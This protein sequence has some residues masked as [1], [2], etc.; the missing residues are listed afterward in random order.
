MDEVKVK[1][2][3]GSTTF[4]G[5]SRIGLVEH[6]AVPCEDGRLF[7]KSATNSGLMS[8]RMVGEV[9]PK[10]FPLLDGSH[11][12]E[13]I[14]GCMSG[15]LKPEQLAQVLDFLFQKG[16]VK[17]IEEPP[18]NLSNGELKRYGSVMRYFS[19]YG[20]RYA[21]LSCFRTAN[22]GIVNA[23]PIAPALASSLV[24][25]GV[26]RLTLLGGSTVGS[27]EVQQSR[28]YQPQDENR[29]R[30]SVWRERVTSERPDLDM[31]LISTDIEEVVDWQELIH[32]TS[33]LIVFLQGPLLFNPWLDR[34]NEAAFALRVPWLTIALLDGESAQIGPTIR[35]GVTACYKCF[36]TRLKSNFSFIGRDEAV[37]KYLGQ[38]R[39]RI[40][41]GMLPPVADIVGGFAAIEVM[42]TLSPETVAQTSG[43][44]MLFNVADFTT[45]FHPV[46]KLPRCPVCS[47]VRNKP[48]PRVW[49]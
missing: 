48:K 44:F 41:F 38:T 9:F 40:D 25:F 29:D 36:E 12:F 34:L 20:S 16:F 13:D 24:H 45:E 43:R 4:N 28:Y 26:A 42:R 11:G 6:Y 15:V 7:M 46:L 3:G 23:G 31:K 30:I 8:G 14:A 33:M 19:R 17:E 35:P 49:S 2:S 18:P 39:E 27:M 5:G 37:E 32:G 1:R 21:S 47:P 10:L 22:V